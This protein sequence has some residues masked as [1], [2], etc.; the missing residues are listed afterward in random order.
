[1]KN[2][3]VAWAL[4]EL[5]DLLDLTG[6]NSFKSRAYRVAARRIQALPKDISDLYREGRLTEIDGIG[7]AIAQKIGELLTTGEI[8]LAQRLRE[9][10]PAG[11]FDVLTV[12]GVGPKR[13][14]QFYRELGIDSLS[15]LKEA[16]KERK[17]RRLKGMGSKIES[18]VLAGI[19]RI[20]NP[21]KK[22]RLLLN[23]ADYYGCLFK[24]RLAQHPQVT[25]VAVAG[26]LRRMVET[27]G[28]LDLVV[29][30]ESPQEVA[31]Y[32][33]SF[34]EFGELVA[35]GPTKISAIHKS[36]FQ[37]DLRIVT[38]QEYP[39]ALL[40]FTGSAD[41]NIRLRQLAKG[42]GFRLSEYGLESTTDSKEVVT[43]ASEAALYAFLGLPY[44]PPELREDRG[45]IEA[46][47]AGELPKLV[48][49]AD[50]RGD[51][52]IHS[53]WS[54]G[55]A[56]VEELARAAAQRGY[57]YIAI[58]DHSRSLKIANGLEL[59]RLKRQ[60]ADIAELNARGDLGITVLT[61]IEVDIL[62][63]RLDYEDDVL[64]EIDVVVASVHSGFK[65]PLERIMARIE[66]AM[67][68]PHVDILAHP[69]GRLLQRRSG[70]A[71]DMNRVIDLAV[72]TGTA[73]EINSF[74]DRLDL[75][76]LTARK[77]LQRGATI[78][79]NTDSHH[80]EQLAYMTYG[81]AMARRAWAGPGQILNC[82]DLTSLR[83]WLRDRGST[84]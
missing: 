75:D 25:E 82:K 79:I 34:P 52:H 43:P 53:C 31:E 42:K 71:V 84:H 23:T 35:N 57:Q 1:M 64:A 40:H 61:G 13:A 28:D 48:E 68:N 16:A 45:E 63:E 32:F 11:L 14:Y 36:G 55:G 67:R 3:E 56:T 29:A 8:S 76:D 15:K 70:Y 80:L 77:A 7:T 22:R 51:L 21:E 9:Q 39:S 54:D 49:L 19:E 62:D 72:E 58:C 18:T 78:V 33:K 2:Y 59:E 30:T 47:L 38:P 73:L 10:I 66:L 27:I 60:H 50:I 26:S 41:H 37:V 12:P 69:T 4:Q 83:K 46:G 6:E 65:Q 44:I 74:P 24:D 81:V 20:E 5:A 17:L